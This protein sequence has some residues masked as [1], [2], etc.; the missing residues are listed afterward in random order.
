[1]IIGKHHKYKEPPLIVQKIN[2]H[3]EHNLKEYLLIISIFLLGIVI[4]IV[5][6]NKTSSIND[7]QEYITTIVNS[8]K[9]NKEINEILLLK[10]S[11]LRN[12]S[13]A[14]LIWL[15]GSTVIGSF[16][17]YI[18]IALKGFSIGYTVSA[19]I[20]TLKLGKGSLFIFTSMFLQYLIYIPVLFALAVSGI[21][22][23]NS[24]IKNKNRE[25]IKLAI[26]R[27]TI[28][29]LFMSLFL[30]FSSFIEVFVSTKLLIIF[31]D[32]I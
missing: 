25:N 19:V 28:F 23:Y 29:S 8:L 24:I 16:A 4:G 3:I 26:L 15:I 27:H 13:L 20:A 21:K 12:V 18:I 6:I 1:M 30:V 11:I 9:S 22:L 7:I 5:F 14:I 32:Y 31:I 10:K 2:S 17:L